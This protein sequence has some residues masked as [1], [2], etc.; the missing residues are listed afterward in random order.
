[1]DDSL[2]RHCYS[3]LNANIGSMRVARRAGKYPASTPVTIKIAA[4]AMYVAGSSA[5]TPNNSDCMRERSRNYGGGGETVIAGRANVY[6]VPVY[7]NP[8]E[9]D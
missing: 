6:V 2:L 5:I 7:E 1:L 4:A 8:D 9:L 3:A